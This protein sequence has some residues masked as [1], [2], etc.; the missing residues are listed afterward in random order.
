MSTHCPYCDESVPDSTYEA[1]L[2]REHGEEL[3]PI[4]RRRVGGHDDGASRRN[5]VLYAGIGIVLAAF[6]VGYLVLVFG[7]GMTSSS[8]AVQPDESAP[9][10]EHGTIDVQYDDTVVEFDDSQYLERDDCF[11]FHGYD[12]AAVWHTHCEGVTIEYALETLGMDVTVD[13][14]A[15]GNETFAEENG[16]DISV[17]ADGEDVDPQEYVLEGVESVDDA[18]AG[19]GD[20]VEI[21]VESSS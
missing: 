7:P 19:A 5:A 8:A 11:H 21:V 3:T 14:F 20:H 13:R 2:R 17:T 12:D 9:V 10:H 18:A 4:D 6:A 1:H 16:D 15:I